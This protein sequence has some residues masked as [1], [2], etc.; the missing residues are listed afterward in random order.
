V[1][2]CFLAENFIHKTPDE[3][4]NGGA[5]AH[6]LHENLLRR[7]TSFFFQRSILYRISNDLTVQCT[8]ETDR[9]MLNG[10]K[11]VSRFANNDDKNHKVTLRV[12][13]TG[14]VVEDDYRLSDV[15]FGAIILFT[16]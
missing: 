14:F 8:I 2:V 15:G 4:K 6:K 9:N 16:C 5:P 1:Y 11:H 7:I 10:I 3:P 13:T 12:W